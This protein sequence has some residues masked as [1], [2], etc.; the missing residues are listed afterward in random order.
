MHGT[1]TR[2]STIR[3]GTLLTL[4]TLFIGVG[5]AAPAQAAQPPVG[6]GTAGTFAV[7]GG[8]AVTNTGPTVMN[9]DLGVSPGTAVTGFPPGLVNGAIHAADAAALQA[10]SDLTVAYNDA[11]G[12]TPAVTV[13]GDLG[14]R[15]LTPGVYKSGSSIL[16]TGTV[17]LDA[18]GD[19]NAV[20]VFQM[21]S[22]LTT[23]TNSR[24]R[25]I[26]G[27]A[28]CNVVWQIGSSATFGTGTDFNGN[29]LALTSISAKTGATFHSR[30]LARNGAVTLDTN[31]LLRGVCPTGS[32][33]P[34]TPFPPTAPG[35]PAVPAT[36]GT[37]AVPAVP[38]TPATPGNGTSI[39]TTNP[40]ETGNTI[41]RYGTDRC[42]GG[43]YRAIVRG[44]AIARVVFHLGGR[45]IATRR[46][47]PFSVRIVTDA[48]VHTLRAHV[49]YDDGTPS[50]DLRLVFRS[51]AQPQAAVTPRPPAFA[52]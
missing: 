39:L 17:T 4:G 49:V 10:K 19:P 33:T 32:T 21:G 15:T 8:A 30:L 50:A 7:L 27:A 36:P 20:F 35:T 51:C 45:T 22:T 28:P 23:A 44:H 3:R 38:A 48:G 43:T 6:L 9:R 13:G 26:N 14:G 18:Q 16:L 34:T 41:G 29:V 47:A 40:P 12:R 37:P 1:T 52:G 25:L 24:V 31:T 46:R 2:T 42:V 11:A 5:I